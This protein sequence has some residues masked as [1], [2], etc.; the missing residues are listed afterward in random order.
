MDDGRLFHFISGSDKHV[1]AVAAMM[2]PTIGFWRHKCLVS[3]S[4]RAL[5][6]PEKN[7]VIRA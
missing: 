6:Q 2:L 3:T 1:T 4:A 5:I 7:F